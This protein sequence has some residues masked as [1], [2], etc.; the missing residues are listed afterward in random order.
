MGNSVAKTQLTG[1]DQV[2]QTPPT[3]RRDSFCGS[4]TSV[5]SSE[6]ESTP[7]VVTTRHSLPCTLSYHANPMSVFDPRSPAYDFARTPLR[8]RKDEVAM[9]DDSQVAEEDITELEFE[10]SHQ[11]TPEKSNIAELDLMQAETPTKEDMSPIVSLYSPMHLACLTFH[12]S[13]QFLS[14]NEQV[15]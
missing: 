5:T 8:V 14:M 11:F 15:H 3:K 12:F 2:P 4:A 13:F 10:T 6:Y 7:D 1:Y 9:V